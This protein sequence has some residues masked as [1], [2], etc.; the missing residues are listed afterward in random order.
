MQVSLKYC[1]VVVV[2]AVVIII[3]AIVMLVSSVSQAWLRHSP[4]LAES[5]NEDLP[6]KKRESL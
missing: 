6:G 4:G 5:F 1:I 3:A 2:A